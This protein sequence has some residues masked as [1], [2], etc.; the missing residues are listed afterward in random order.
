[1]FRVAPIMQP[2]LSSSPE[3]VLEH[4]RQPERKR[5]TYRPPAW[6]EKSAR[7]VFLY[8]LAHDLDQREATQHRER[9][10]AD[11]R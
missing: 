3:A 11:V 8:A 10:G 9:G 1:V 5:A 4:Y 6:S 2:Q 7:E